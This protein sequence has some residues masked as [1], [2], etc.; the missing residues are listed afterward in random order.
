[1]GSNLLTLNRALSVVYTAT[2]PTA[3]STAAAAQVDLEQEVIQVCCHAGASTKGREP[4]SAAA[5]HH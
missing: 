1:M 2:D 3:A 4:H 5:P